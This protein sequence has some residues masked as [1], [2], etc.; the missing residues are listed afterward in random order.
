MGSLSAIL[1]LGLRSFSARATPPKVPPLPTEQV[2]PSTLPSVWFQISG[3][4]VR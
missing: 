1:M 3:P 4:V 2:K